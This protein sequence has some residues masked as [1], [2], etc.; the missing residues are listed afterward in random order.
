MLLTSAEMILKY[1]IVMYLL[2]FHSMYTNTCSL[3]KPLNCCNMTTVSRSLTC[4]ITYQEATITV[5]LVIF[6]RDLFLRTSET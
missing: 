5:W 3:L 6:A 4:K 1:S 2:K